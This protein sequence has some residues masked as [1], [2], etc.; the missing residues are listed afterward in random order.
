MKVLASIVQ[1]VGLALIALSAGYFSIIAGGIVLGVET[2][3][4]G[5]ALER[6]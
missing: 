2:V 1:L 3:V 5:L 4:V 6:R